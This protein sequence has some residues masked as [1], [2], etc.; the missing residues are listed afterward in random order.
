VRKDSDASCPSQPARGQVFWQWEH[1]TGYRDYDAKANLRIEQAYQRGEA[2][3]RLKSG[4]IGTIPMEIFFA[5]ML[6]YDPVS[7]NTRKVRRL[8]PSGLL[9]RLWRWSAEVIRSIETGKPRRLMFKQYEQN[10]KELF[11]GSCLE[12]CERDLYK[13]EGIPQQVARSR[14]FFACSM[15]AVL[16][17]VVWMGIDAD[18]NDAA[19]IPEAEWYFQVAEHLFCSFFTIEVSIRF[20]AFAKKTDAMEDGWFIFD[21]MLVVAQ[22]SETWLLT[23][24]LSGHRL[25]QLALLRVARLLRLARL[26]RLMRMLRLFPEVLT[27]LKG[28]GRAMRPVFYVLMMLGILLFVFAII[29]KTQAIDNEVLEQMFPS[30]VD[31]M[32]LLLLRGTL[33]DGPA[34]T[35]YAI[36]DVAPALAVTFLVFIFLSSFTVLNMLIGILC[37]VV[38]QV[39]KME[40]EDA[41][42]A[43]LKT[44]LLGL[45]ECYDRNDDK[46]IGPEEFDLLMMNPETS[47]ILR[48]FDVDASGLMSLKD[49]LFEHVAEAPSGSAGQRSAKPSKETSASAETTADAVPG[50][51]RNDQSWKSFASE[52]GE[53][54]KLNFADLLEVILRLRGGKSATVTDIADLREYTKLRLDNV[55]LKLHEEAEAQTELKDVREE[56]KVIRQQLSRVLRSQGLPPDGS[57]DGFVLGR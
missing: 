47:Q 6:Q 27:L 28:I 4:K 41:S 24:F 29:F 12:R 33:L 36:Y 57:D 52:R 55:E 50:V 10:R 17:N 9:Q 26:G 38:C 14:T 18:L 11:Q 19:T 25:K 46:R 35:F 34:I 2:Y 49:V 7:A 8:G 39:S 23:L 22:I 5:D 54:R 43:L 40:Q 53:G 31:T 37:D 21:A 44:T 56:L 15:I 16:L 42:L 45:L 13:S 51:P 32:W 30:L 3:V 20:L 1:R 48:R